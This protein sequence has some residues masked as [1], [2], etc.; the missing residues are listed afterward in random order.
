MKIG[1]R[2]GH[3][4]LITAV[5]S[6]GRIHPMS[7]AETKS[8]SAPARTPVTNAIP[9][10][11][12]VMPANQKEGRDPF[13]PDSERPYANLT[14]PKQPVQTK[15]SPT[16]FILNG[17]S[18]SGDH[19]L[20]M[21]NGRTL[22]EGEESEINTVAGRVTV[23]CVEIKTDSVVIEVGNERKELRLRGN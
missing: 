22:A 7:A 18:G 16:A 23:R 19:R 10:S 2:F 21:I 11:T 8:P 6:I 15:I 17:L 4:L 13:Y 9:Q 1:L 20:A 3:T 14:G 5:A 12:F